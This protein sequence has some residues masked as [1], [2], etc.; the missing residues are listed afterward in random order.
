M[1]VLY[2]FALFVYSPTKTIEHSHDPDIRCEGGVAH[3]RSWGWVGV[4]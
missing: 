1:I 4:A 3:W 2:V